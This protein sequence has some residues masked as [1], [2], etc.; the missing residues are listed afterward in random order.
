MARRFLTHIDLTNFALIGAMLDPRTSDPGGLGV[1]DAGR[2]WF[3]T[4]TG[5][6]K[7]WSG[8]A[9]IDLLDLASMAGTITAAKVSDFT[10]AVQ[11]ISWGSLANPTADVNVGGHKV[12]N[13]ADGTAGSD[14]ASYGQLIALIN[15]RG[16]KDPV[17]AATT[18]NIASLAGGA[19]NAIDGVTLAGG[20]RVLV[21][22]QSTGSLN[23]I[24]TVT[25][26]GTGA[27]GTWTR[28]TDADSATE[29]PPGSV[30][31]VQEGTANADK[32]F[33]L[34]TNGPI[35]LGT[36]PLVFSAYGASSGEIVT[37]GDGLTKTGST[38]D[39]LPALDDTV[40]VTSDRVGANTAR[41]PRKWQGTIPATSGTVDTLT[42]TVSGSTVTINHGTGNPNA[43]VGVRYGSAGTTPGQKVEVDDSASDANNVVLTFPAGPSANQYTFMVVA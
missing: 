38:L 10:T 42:V 20:D 31:S 13:I 5:R 36:T 41:V 1:G 23:G 4:D 16:F 32:M 43:I 9:A 27:N 21:K 30:V 6:P 29:L 19:P 40:T 18:A 12:T 2:T 15:N 37:A 11:A 35:V 28:A 8:T 17:R 24:Y 39:V 14:A 34:A 3:R 26:L 33:M 7:V 25:T 22:D